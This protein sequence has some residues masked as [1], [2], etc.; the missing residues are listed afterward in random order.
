MNPN[1]WAGL[2]DRTLDTYQPAEL[3]IGWLRYEALRKLNAHQFA[4]L[5]KRN[6]KGERFDDMVDQ[7]V[8]RE[9][10]VM[11]ERHDER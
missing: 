2:T 8:E 1:E 4:E 9:R 11:K 10:A 5:C 3:A 6:L 7:L